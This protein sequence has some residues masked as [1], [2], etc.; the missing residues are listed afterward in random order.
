M[1]HWFEDESFWRE[2]YPAMFPEARHEKAR[3][4]VEQVLALAGLADSTGLSILDLC[5]GPGRHAIE[6]AA[7]HRV[8]CVDRTPFLLDK[9]RELAAQRGVK[10]E[11]VQ[12]DMAEFKREG[13]F[14][15]AINLFTSFGYY[16][17]REEDA[18][19]LR[20]LHASLKPGG[21]LVMD[22]VSKERVARG[23]RAAHADEG[24][25]W[26][27]FQRCRVTDDWGRLENAWT[28][29]RGDTARTWRFSHN[30][31]SGHELKAALHQAGFKHVQ[32]YGSLDAAPYDY[33]A[34]RLVAVA[35]KDT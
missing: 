25:G 1:P 7:A 30:I 27:L 12:A 11:F 13:A 16:P 15:L 26:V 21:A 6:L 35:R 31:Y 32:L 28:L 5:C 34:A 9:A 14:D 24:D 33:N 20:N 17:T 8:T 4:E 22:V 2:L 3:Q 18:R 29:L 10:A 19:V 23:F